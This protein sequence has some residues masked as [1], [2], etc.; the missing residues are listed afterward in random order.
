[1]DR[2]DWMYVRAY[3]PAVGALVIAVIGAKVAATL[4]GHPL[5]VGLADTAKWIP[6]GALAVAAL[7]TTWTT[8][9]IWQAHNGRG[10]LCECGGLLGREQ[11]GRADRGGPFRRCLAC[12]RR[13]NHRHYE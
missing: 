13:I 12:T 1:M 2:W 3:A 6:V 8:Y 7:L 4:Q 10:L 9:R 11:P 5:L